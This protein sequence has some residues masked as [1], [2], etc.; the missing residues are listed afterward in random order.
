MFTAA[1]IGDAVGVTIANVDRYL[2]NAASVAISKGQLVALD[3]KQTEATSIG[4]AF[5]LAKAVAA[6]TDNFGIYAI[7]LEDV[8]ASD[9]TN[10]VYTK[11]KFRMA[12][13]VNALIGDSTGGSSSAQENSLLWYFDEGDN[14]T[15]LD[16]TQPAFALSEAAP[17]T[18]AIHFKPCLGILL[19]DTSATFST[20]AIT[21][22]LP[23]LFNGYGGF[24]VVPI[25]EAT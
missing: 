20:D 18:G 16:I 2:Y 22:L 23:I 3:L 24:P 8:A 9:V 1:P 6:A 4:A 14:H 11:G 15:Y 12:G 10:N 21:E 25:V 7:A 13:R 17:N 19:K 5:T